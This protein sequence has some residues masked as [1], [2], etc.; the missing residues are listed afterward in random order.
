VRG[1]LFEVSD[2]KALNDA[3]SSAALAAFDRYPVPEVIGE[4]T[5]KQARETLILRLKQIDLHPPKFVKDVIL[6]YAQQIFDT[7]PIH[8]ELRRRDFQMITAQL[9]INLVNMHDEF[10]NS[11]DMPALLRELGVPFHPSGS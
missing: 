6:P 8:E 7:Q 5:W 3:V 1:V 2:R 10:E 4:E 11:V 9:R